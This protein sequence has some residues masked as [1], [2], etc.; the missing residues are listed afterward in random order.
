VDIDFKYVRNRIREYD[1][2]NILNYCFKTLKEFELSKSPVPIWDVLKLIEWTYLFSNEQYPPKIATELDIAK[3]LSYIHQLQDNHDFFR[4]SKT[5]DIHKGFKVIASQQTWLQDSIITNDFG[6]Q[7]LLYT[8][9]KHKYSFEKKF[10][11]DNGIDIVLF[12]KIKFYTYLYLFMDQMSEFKYYGR[13]TDDYFRIAKE[14]FKEEQINTFFNILTIDENNIK[15]ELEDGFKK[16]L[17]FDLKVFDNKFFATYP[18][19]RKHNQIIILHR[20]IFNYTAKNFLYDY[21]KKT[22]SSFTEEFGKRFEKYVELGIKETSL[23]YI[24]ENALKDKYGKKEKVVDFCLNGNILIECKAIESKAYPSIY[25]SNEV[26]F[27]TY[28]DSIVKAYTSQ[29]YSVATKIKGENSEKELWGIIITYK[30]LIIGNGV[31]AWNSF[32]KVEMEKI[33]KGNENPLPPENLF[34]I[35]IS[36]WDSI[37]F[38]LKNKKINIEGLLKKV[39][40]DDSNLL[41]K[42]FFFNMHLKSFD[43]TGN[44]PQYLEDSNQ[45]VNFTS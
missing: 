27:N 33:L 42:N 23:P 21:F 11:E 12:L 5:N 45:L 34:F 9:L 6:R 10:Q 8:Q 25:P 37:V 3:L 17:S 39:R 24:D 40:T 22:D 43:F 31:D 26:L 7:V 30:E 4:L 14:V 16:I 13:L 38:L 29:M 41:T 1:K 20:K 32:I 28:K 19:L 35:D 2:E 15:Q 44:K 36:T 18:F